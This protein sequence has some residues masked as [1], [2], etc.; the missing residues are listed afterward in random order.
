M[1][2]IAS[3]PEREVVI[4]ALG[5]IYSVGS[6]VDEEWCVVGVIAPTNSNIRE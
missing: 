1:A 5:T 6:D 4:A 2:A 3:F